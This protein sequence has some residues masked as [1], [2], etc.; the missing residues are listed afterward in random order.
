MKPTNPFFRQS[1]T[2]VGVVTSGL[3]IGGCETL[4]RISKPASEQPTTTSFPVDP[5]IAKQTGSSYRDLGDSRGKLLGDLKA[6]FPLPGF[7]GDEDNS[8]ETNVVSNT[9]QQPVNTY[10]WR[11]SL[12]TVAFLPIDVADVQGGIINT[13]WY[14]D[15]EKLGERYK[16][17]IIVISDELRSDGVRVGIVQ[18]EREGRDGEWTPKVASRETADDLRAIIVGR[19]LELSELDAN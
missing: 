7:F 13:R 6:E 17:N 9:S 12:D 14:E 3:L 11:A 2:A 1:L 8:E 19:A 15:P 10:L 18:E 5:D 16:V 4:D